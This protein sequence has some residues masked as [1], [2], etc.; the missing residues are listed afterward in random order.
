MQE[1][2]TLRLS[3]GASSIMFLCRFSIVPNEYRSMCSSF[4]K[5]LKHAFCGT[6]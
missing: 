4:H 6:G 5:P 1:K 2:E 3:R